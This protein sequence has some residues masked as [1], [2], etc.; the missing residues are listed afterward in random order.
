MAKNYTAPTLGELRKT[1][2]KQGTVGRPIKIPPRKC[3]DAQEFIARLD[4]AYKAT[5]ESSIQ[6]G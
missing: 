2:V 6:F 4:R 5:K 1:F 3:K